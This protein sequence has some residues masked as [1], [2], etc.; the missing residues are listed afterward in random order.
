MFDA[1]IKTIYTNQLL[2]TCDTKKFQKELITEFSNSP[3]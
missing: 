3:G 1:K 2:K